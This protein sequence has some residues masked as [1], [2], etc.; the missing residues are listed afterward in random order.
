MSS[1]SESD[2]PTPNK[3]KNYDL[4]FKLEAAEY[5]EKHDKS[6]ASRHFKVGRTQIRDWVRDKD[7]IR[8]QL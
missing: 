5:A 1:D 8:D 7:K 6:K 4:K 2:G 3:R